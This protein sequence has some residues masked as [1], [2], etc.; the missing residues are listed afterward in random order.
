V[1][2]EFRRPE[3]PPLRIETTTLW[4]YPSQNYQGPKSGGRQGDQNYIGAT[5]SWVI[6]QLLSR[7]TRENDLLVDPMCGSGTSLDVAM[8]LGRKARG[9]DLVSRREDIEAADARDLPLED[10]CADFWF[11][12]PPYSTHIDYSDDPRCIGKLDASASAGNVY[13]EAMDA[14]FAEAHRVLKNRRYLG[15]YVSDSFRRKR[16]GP[17][18]SGGGELMPIG[19]RLFG[20]LEKR[21][22]PIDIVAVV[23]GNQKLGRSTHHQE[24]AE[25]NFFLRGF[26]YLLIMKKVD[27]EPARDRPARD[28]GP[29][30]RGSKKRRS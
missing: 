17:V 10:G 5:P 16:G 30:D 1:P 7:Y 3:R 13:F 8:D 14:V 12:D 18:G 22:K 23:R 28:R 9:F 19:F 24:A 29:P 2:R 6:W 15:V 25:E 26:N 20:L 21:F 11:V 27:D 4:S